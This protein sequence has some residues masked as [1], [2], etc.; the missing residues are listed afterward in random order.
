MR[1]LILDFIKSYLRGRLDVYVFVEAYMELYKL[2]RESTQCIPSQDELLL[3]EILSTIF[4]IAD[5]FNLEDDRMEY[6]FDEKQIYSRV[7]TEISRLD[8]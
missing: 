5:N 7:N 3:D 4:L 1:L 6:E 8:I 2:L